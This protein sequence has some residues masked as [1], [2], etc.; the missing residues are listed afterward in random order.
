MYWYRLRMGLQNKKKKDEI[1]WEVVE[2]I[3]W[4]KTDTTGGLLCT[5]QRKTEVPLGVE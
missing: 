1:E 4:V 3:I 2:R 5:R